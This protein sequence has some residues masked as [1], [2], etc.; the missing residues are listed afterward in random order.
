MIQQL[1]AKNRRSQSQSQSQTLS[2]APPRSDNDQNLPGETRRE[3]S[4][5]QARGEADPDQD[6]ERGPGPER[7]IPDEPYTSFF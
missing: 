4:D 7:Q 6:V 1:I 3:R 5:E 2:Q